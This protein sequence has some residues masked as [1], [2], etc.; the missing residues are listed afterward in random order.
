MSNVAAAAFCAVH[1]GGQPASVRHGQ[2]HA[3][4]RARGTWKRSSRPLEYTK[5]NAVPRHRGFAV[6]HARACRGC[7][8]V[9]P[10]ASA[11]RRS[12]SS[13]TKKRPIDE[14]G[15]AERDAARRLLL[16]ERGLRNGRAADRRLR[17]IRLVHRHPR[18]RGR[19]QGRKPARATSSPATTATSTCNA[20]P[21]S[22]SPI[23]ARRSC[24]T[25]A[26]CRSATTRTPTMPC[27]SAPRRPRSPRSTT[28]P[29]RRRTPPYRRGCPTSWPR[30]RFAH[31]LKVMARD[32]I[33][34]F[35]E[36]SDCESLAEPLDRATT[37]TQSE[38]RAR[39]RRPSIRCA[40][41][42]G[43]G[44]GDPGQAGLLQ[45]GGASAAVAADGGADDIAAHGG[46]HP[47][48]AAVSGGLFRPGNS[49]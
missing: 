26:S 49:P 8:R 13:T 2:L 15:K 22:A 12:T 5:W 6:R 32:K 38:R 36:A 27:S 41:R 47:H 21:R 37:S 7:W 44:R 1:R 24:R 45:R 25:S 35:M 10:M 42:E 40:R 9:C 28:D 11:P 18:R 34:S 17:P 20:R 16:D 4:C 39:R 43:R 29:R 48:A 33:G 14:D 3:S 46:S 30:S 23:A 31:Y 19:R